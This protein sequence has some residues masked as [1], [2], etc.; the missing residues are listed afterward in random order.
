MTGLNLIQSKKYPKQNQN[1]KNE[2][3]MHMKST[4]IIRRMDDLGRVVIP[5]ELQKRIAAVPGQP[6][7]IFISKNSVTFK[8]YSVFGEKKDIADQLIGNFPIS[9]D[10]FVAVVDTDS[11][12]SVKT[13]KSHITEALLDSSISKTL[14]DVITET[15]YPFKDTVRDIKGNSMVFADYSDSTTTGL[16]VKRIYHISPTTGAVVLFSKSENDIEIPEHVNSIAKYICSVLDSAN[17]APYYSTYHKNTT[18]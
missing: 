10:L 11:V 17:Y 1:Y 15:E 16:F 12:V 2:R 5:K 6:F 4:G 8:K 13:D 3:M 7:E 14:S 9:K 18:F